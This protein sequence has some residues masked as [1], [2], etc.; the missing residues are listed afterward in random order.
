MGPM[1]LQGVGRSCLDIQNL[2]L[3]SILKACREADDWVPKRYYFLRGM[4]E[5]PWGTLRGLDEQPVL[6]GVTGI[7]GGHGGLFVHRRQAGTRS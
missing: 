3:K 4:W 5:L 7:A 6:V 1:F 2:V